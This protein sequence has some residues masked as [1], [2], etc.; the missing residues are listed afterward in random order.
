[1]YLIRFVGQMVL[2]TLASVFYTLPVPML[3]LIIEVVL[4]IFSY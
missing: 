3:E 4:I 1:M 2:L